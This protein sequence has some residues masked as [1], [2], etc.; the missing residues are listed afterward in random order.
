MAFLQRPWCRYGARMAFYRVPTEFL[1]AILCAPKTLSLRFHGAHICVH[2]AFMAF[3]LY[4][5]RV[6]D[7]VTSQ[8]TLYNLRTNPRDDHGI[9]KTI[10]VRSREAPIALWE[11]LLCGYGYHTATPL[12]RVATQYPFQNS[13]TFH[14]LSLTFNCFPDPFGKPILAIFIHRLFEDFAQIFELADLLLKEKS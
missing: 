7:A 2:C 12:R 6:G 5:R 13:L 4:W 11:I 8:R 1:L 3:T 10:L 9:Y 14:W